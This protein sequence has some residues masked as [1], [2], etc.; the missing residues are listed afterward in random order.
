[1]GINPTLSDL[2]G[3]GTSKLDWRYLE[4]YRMDRNELQIR[5]NSEKGTGTKMAEKM[6]L[7][8]LQQMYSKH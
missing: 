3:P 7:L 4:H 1:M 6:T 2:Q 5:T 8:K